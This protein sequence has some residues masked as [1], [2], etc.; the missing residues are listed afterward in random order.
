M[1]EGRRPR[2]QTLSDKGVAALPRRAGVYFHPDPELPKHGV[3]VR[4]AGPG[5]FTVIT[6][7]PYGKQKWVKV[8]STAEMSIAAAREKA[9]AVIARVG[10]GLN[11]FE[12]RPI[13]PDTV[14]DVF[15]EYLKRHVEARKL[16]TRAEMR[17]LLVVYVLPRWRDRP[18][19]G[20]RRSDV[21]RLLDAVEDA[22]GPWMADAVLTQ[23]RSVASWYA[24]RNDDYQPPFTRNMRRVPE[25]ARRRAR[26]L[27]DGELR[28]VWAAAE[29]AGAYGALIKFLLLTGVRLGKALAL[30]WADIAPDGVWTLPTAPREKGNP[31]TLSLPPAALAVIYAQPRFVD[32]TRVFA[33]RGSLPLTGLGRAKAAFDKVCGVHGWTLHDCRRTARSLMS[34]AGVPSEHAERVLGHVVSGIEGT[35]DRYSYAREKADA[36]RKL[37]ALI[38]TIVN[39]PGDNVVALRG[40][41]S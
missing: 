12:P 39:P 31:G 8:G 38:E 41:E 20:I 37:A 26:V 21:A 27:D 2:R 35:Y 1:A 22:H 17:R 40:A 7:D 34:R 9:R 19:A 16:R 18:F 29:C 13:E 10:Q 6:R 15:E 4:P 24:G 3:R 33:G 32:N 23:L 28:K 30:R 25:E 14:A 5:A 36:L 11:P